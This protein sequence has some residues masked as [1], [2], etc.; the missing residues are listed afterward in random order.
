MSWLKKAV[1]KIHHSIK[2]DWRKVGHSLKRMSQGRFH[3]GHQ[4]RTVL[5]KSVRRTFDKYRWS[6]YVKSR[7]AGNNSAGVIDL[8]S[9]S[10]GGGPT[11]QYSGK[12]LSDLVR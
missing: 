8:S 10:Y 6:K 7:L 1:H 12:S 11:Y 9:A 5:P 3:V 4:I 2:K